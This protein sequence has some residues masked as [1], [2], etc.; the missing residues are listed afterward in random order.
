MPSPDVVERLSSLNLTT[1]SLH[2][3]SAIALVALANNFSFPIVDPYAAGQ[4]DLGNFQFVSYGS[5]STALLVGLF[6][7]S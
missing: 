1:G 3:V 2:L 5:V 6:S 7:A 4:H